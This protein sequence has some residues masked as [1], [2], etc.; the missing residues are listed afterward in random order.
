MAIIQNAQLYDPFDSDWRMETE[1]LRP[2]RN[3]I[4]LAEQVCR[5]FGCQFAHMLRGFPSI[6]KTWSKRESLNAIGTVKESTP[7]NAFRD[8]YLCLHFTDNWNE[9]EGVEWGDIYL[10]EKHTSP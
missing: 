6:D 3:H 4:I 7:K 5:F 1:V 8:L 2:P 10:D 9:E